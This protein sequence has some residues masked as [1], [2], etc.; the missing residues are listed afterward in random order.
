MNL[1]IMQINTLPRALRTGSPIINPT[2]NKKIEVKY[3]F[4]FKKTSA[5]KE[6]LHNGY[7]TIDLY[8]L[9]SKFS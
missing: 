4:V 1:S 5:S 7:H 8:H 2:R 9:I 3:F 6:F